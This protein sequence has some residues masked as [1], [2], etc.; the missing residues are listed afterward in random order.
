MITINK[1]TMDMQVVAGDTG[2]FTMRP[3]FNVDGT[4]VY[5][6]SE[7]NSAM[8]TFNLYE[9]KRGLPIISKSVTEFEDGWFTIPISR[10]ETSTLN[11][12]NYLYELKMFRYADGDSDDVIVDTL[13]PNAKDTAYFTV[14]KGDENLQ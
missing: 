2:D 11:N 1:T 13:L 6:L 14:K 12:G 5:P 7:V 9:L 8:V 3:V 4:R 10:E